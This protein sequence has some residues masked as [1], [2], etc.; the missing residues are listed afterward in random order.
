MLLIAQLCVAFTWHPNAF[1]TAS[2][3]SFQS[4][5]LSYLQMTWEDVIQGIV[6]I[7]RESKKYGN[8]AQVFLASTEQ[9]TLDRDLYSLS[10]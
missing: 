3:E 1:F 8:D 5:W 9:F 2:W 4:P 10:S 7:Y 6:V